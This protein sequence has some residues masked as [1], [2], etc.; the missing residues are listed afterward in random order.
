MSAAASRHGAAMQRRDQRIANQVIA[1]WQTSGELVAA[2][3]EFNA[4]ARDIGRF[5]QCLDQEL[6]HD[7]S[8]PRMALRARSCAAL[9][10]FVIMKAAWAMASGCAP[11]R[12]KL[13]YWSGVCIG[14]SS[15][16]CHTTGVSVCRQF[17][18]AIRGVTERTTCMVGG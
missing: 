3:V 1:E 15:S 5:E 4:Q 12:W 9:D 16:A 17:W 8:S 11:G 6:A 18:P 2:V 10:A 14:M 13:R 7:A